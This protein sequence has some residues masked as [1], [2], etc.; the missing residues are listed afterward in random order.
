VPPTISSNQQLRRI[1]QLVLT[2]AVVTAVCLWAATGIL[3]LAVPDGHAWT[4]TAI[5]S[6]VAL[7]VAAAAVTFG[8]ERA[9]P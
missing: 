1:P 7:F 4:W 9:K 3:L 2:S 5:A 8:R 6:V